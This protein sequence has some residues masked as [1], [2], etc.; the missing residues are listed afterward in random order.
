MNGRMG[1]FWLIRTFVNFILHIFFVTSLHT[2]M[3]NCPIIILAILILCITMFYL[4]DT[5]IC[6][7]LSLW[8]G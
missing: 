7:F 4:S 8:L 1:Q 2:V 6:A 3:I 5:I